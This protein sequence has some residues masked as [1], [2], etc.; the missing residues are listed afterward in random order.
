MKRSKN[1]F[2]VLLGL[3]FFIG[4]VDFRWGNHFVLDGR[5]DKQIDSI[6]MIICSEET[7]FTYPIKDSIYQ[8]L[9]S[10][11]SNVS[12]PE[13][14][15]PCKVSFVVFLKDEKVLL[16]GEDFDCNHCDADHVYFLSRDSIEYE[17]HP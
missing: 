10:F 2:V 1:L 6:R 15:Y 11:E 7:M 8:D 4:C 16:E 9:V 3:L 12:T 13:T 17:Y 5:F 14:G